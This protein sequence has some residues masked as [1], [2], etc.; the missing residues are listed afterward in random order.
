[1]YERFG[2]RADRAIDKLA[3]NPGHVESLA[4]LARWY[5][6]R[7]SWEWSAEL[8]EE[9]RR[10]GGETAS[11]PLARAYWSLGRFDDAR[12]AF[13]RARQRKEA[14]AYFLRMCEQTMDAHLLQQRNHPMP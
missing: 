1:M 5:A 13:E 12:E 4:L 14:P 9:V 6:F 3:E 10:R 2:P 7:E 11:L 8:F